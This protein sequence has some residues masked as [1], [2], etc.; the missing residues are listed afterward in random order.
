MFEL[1]FKIIP[2]Q[3]KDV[4]D[5]ILFP[6]RWIPEAQEVLFDFFM[7][8]PSGFVAVVKFSL[9]LFPLLLWISAMWCTQLS[10]YTIPFRS[11]RVKFYSM[12]LLA[13]WDAARAVWFYWVGLF[14][15][16]GVCIGWFFSLARLG[17]NLLVEVVKQ[18]FILPF[19]MTGEIT[20]SYS[21]PGVPWIA[22]FMLV[23]WCLLESLIFTYT[24]FPTVS[25]LLADLAGVQSPQFTGPVLYMFLLMLIFGSFACVQALIEAF[26]KREIRYIIQMV[27]VEIFVM[28]FEVM[29]L[30]RELVDAIT[31]WIAMQT[32]GGAALGVVFT[33]SLACFGWAGI[34]AM[35]WFLFGQF[36]TPLLLAFISRQ[37]GMAPSG[38]VKSAPGSTQSVNWWSAPLQ[39]FKAEIGWLHEKSDEI[40]EYLTLPILHVLAAAINFSLILVATR[41]VFNL[42]FKNLKEVM[43]THQALSSIEMRARKATS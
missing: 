6:I 40:L 4:F 38:S 21:Q 29:F 20:K 22:F 15:V 35:T 23:F 26:Q 30:Y 13:W 28:F 14:R 2:E 24:L 43:G 25:E 10:L 18:V 31:P 19:R 16:I 5:I 34:R 32:G 42:P 33:L 1:I 7:D 39:E 3:W 37:D 11:N 12:I 36:G 41:T 8:S 9:L 17:L 27:M